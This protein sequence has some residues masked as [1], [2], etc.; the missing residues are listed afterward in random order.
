M[1]TSSF[2]HDKRGVSEIISSVIMLL[3]VSV[4]GV[5]VYSY[6][7]GALSSTTSFFQLDTNSKENRVQERFAVIAVWSN[8]PNRL[9]LTVLNYGQIDLTIDAV[10]INSTSVTSYLGGIDRAIGKGVLIQVCFTSPI[11]I[12]SGSIY[13]IVVVSNRGSRNAIDWK[14]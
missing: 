8:Q 9:N 14:A 2:V 3:I 4:A 6:S 5:A 7:T 10:Y 13:N 12:Q 1:K 11:T